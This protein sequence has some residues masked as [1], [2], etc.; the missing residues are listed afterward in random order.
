MIVQKVFCDV[1]GGDIT[2]LKVIEV[3]LGADRRQVCCNE[4]CLDELP[5]KA[6]EMVERADELDRREEELFEKLKRRK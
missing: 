1:C 3:R 6:R 4:E 2:G 5:S